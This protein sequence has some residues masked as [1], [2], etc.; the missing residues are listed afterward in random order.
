MRYCIL[1][2]SLFII[3]SGIGCSYRN[4]MCIISSPVEVSIRDNARD[5]VDALFNAYQ[6]GTRQAFE[7]LVS[8]DFAPDKFAFLSDVETGMYSGKTLETH[9]FINMV[10]TNRDTVAVSCTWEKK[11]VPKDTAT[12]ILVSAHADFIFVVKN[13]TWFLSKIRGTNPF[14]A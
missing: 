1:I 9:F 11:S 10:N 12:P 5:A 3:T 7:P 8:D 6:Q 2:L 14:Q 4:I 13:N